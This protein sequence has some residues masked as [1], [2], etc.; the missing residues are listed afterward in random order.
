MRNSSSE[1]EQKT[2]PEDELHTGDLGALEKTSQKLSR[3][4][5]TCGSCQKK[6]DEGPTGTGLVVKVFT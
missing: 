2:S 1:G 4:Y 6:G 3:L 5:Y